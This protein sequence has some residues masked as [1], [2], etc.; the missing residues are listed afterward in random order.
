MT[1]ITVVG[2]FKTLHQVACMKSNNWHIFFKNVILSSTDSFTPFWCSFHTFL[3]NFA[4]TCKHTYCILTDKIE[5]LKS[6]F[7]CILQTK[8]NN[9]NLIFFCILYS[10]VQFIHFL[11]ILHKLSNTLHPNR[12]NWTKKSYFLCKRKIIHENIWAKYFSPLIGLS[13]LMDQ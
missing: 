6:Y 2:L 7:F 13:T 8:L 4:E 10:G 9:W 3:L 5:Q 1:S 12:Q 11:W